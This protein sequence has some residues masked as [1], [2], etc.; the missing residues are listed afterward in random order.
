MPIDAPYEPSPSAAV[1]E[2]VEVYERTGG[3]RGRTVRGVPCVIVS[4]LGARSGV[5]RKTPLIRVEHEGRYAAVASMGGAPQ[6]PVW[7]HNLTAHPD[8]VTVQD[9]ATVLDCT[10]HE[11]TGPERDEWWARA[12]A[13]WPDYDAYQAKTDRR[14]PLFVLTPTA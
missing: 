1:A 3:E 13:V 12:V 6:H 10:A 2:Q 14:I 11:A 7:Y 4:S 9:G 8:V 5:Q